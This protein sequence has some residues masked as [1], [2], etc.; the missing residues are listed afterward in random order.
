MYTWA[1]KSQVSRKSKREL[2]VYRVW[3]LDL[4]EYIQVNDV[5]QSQLVESLK[6]DSLTSSIIQ[7][8]HELLV[9]NCSSLTTFC[10]TL[11]L[12]WTLTTKLSCGKPRVN[13]VCDCWWSSKQDKCVRFLLCLSTADYRESH[14]VEREKNH[15]WFC[16]FDFSSLGKTVLEL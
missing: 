11:P 16:V 14:S 13:L 12:S 6:R 15:F 3:A 2:W 5:K 10:K 7:S 9:V 8:G 1:D 4:L